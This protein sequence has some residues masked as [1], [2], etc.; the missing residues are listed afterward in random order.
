VK[1]FETEGKQKVARDLRPA[2]AK[3]TANIELSE[4]GAF[5]GG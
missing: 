5:S 1:T 2:T 3:N 4:A